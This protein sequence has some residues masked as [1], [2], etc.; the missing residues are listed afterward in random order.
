MYEVTKRDGSESRTFRTAAELL[1]WAIKARVFGHNVGGVL[2]PT[3]FDHVH[4]GCRDGSAGY[5]YHLIDTF[6]PWK[7]TSDHLSAMRRARARY[8]EILHYLREI[9][10]EWRPDTSVSPD[11]M[12]YFADNSTELHE[13][14]KDGRRRYRMVTAPHGDAC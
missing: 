5:D 12:A 3:R 1:H 2:Y 13:V 9:E 14:S 8:V 10:P 7:I 6:C 4:L 11:G